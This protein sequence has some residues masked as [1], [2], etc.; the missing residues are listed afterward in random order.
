MGNY[1]ED[2]L[3]ELAIATNNSMYNDCY[4]DY[5]ISLYYETDEYRDNL[6]RKSVLE[7]CV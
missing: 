7:F 3:K 5:E 2:E 1:T 4:F 6:T